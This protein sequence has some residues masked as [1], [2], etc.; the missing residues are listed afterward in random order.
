MTKTQK[1]ALLKSLE[2]S[3]NSITNRLINHRLITNNEVTL[4]EATF[5][6]TVSR[7]ILFEAL[8]DYIPGSEDSVDDPVQDD[9]NIQDNMILK[10]DE[11][12][13]YMFHPDTGTLESLSI[14]P[15]EISTGSL[16]EVDSGFAESTEIKQEEE[17]ELTES[18]AICNSLLSFYK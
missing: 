14:K 12:N 15:E 11:G 2:E 17:E 1:Q 3:S 5:Y 9:N 8:E 16:P 13:E 10:D 7:E 6:N 18:E 4:E